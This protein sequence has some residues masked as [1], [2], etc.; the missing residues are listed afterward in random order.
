MVYLS[1]SRRKAMV[2][3][4]EGKV[5]HEGKYTIFGQVMKQCL[6]DS[7]DMTNFRQKDPDS[8]CYKVDFKGEGSM[9]YGG[10]FRDSLSNIARELEESV[11]PL[12]VKT[13]NNR[14][15]HG[16]YRDCYILNGASKTP[17]NIEMFK[18]F[19]GFIAYA[20]MSKS[21][22]PFNLAPIVWK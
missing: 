6:T 9:D 3:A 2:F 1:V 10:P 7:P 12:L 18:F 21:P 15:E 20:I 4:D 16:S 11:L 5:D 19:G 14:N 8:R 22:V 13:P 17:S